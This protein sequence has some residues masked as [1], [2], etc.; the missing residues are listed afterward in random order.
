MRYVG[1]LNA[2]AVALPRMVDNP[3]VPLPTTVD[4]ICPRG[5]IVELAVTVGLLVC[6]LVKLVVLVQLVVLLLVVLL[7]GVRLRVEDCDAVD[8]PEVL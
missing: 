8:V 1:S 7:V 3:D 6:V 2:I 5:D 4:I